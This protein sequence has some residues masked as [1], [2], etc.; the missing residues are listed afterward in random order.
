MSNVSRC[1][2]ARG[3]LLGKNISNV[4][5]NA[6]SLLF[7]IHQKSKKCCT[8]KKLKENQLLHV[9]VKV[10]SEHFFFMS[11]PDKLPYYECRLVTRQHLCFRWNVQIFHSQWRLY[12]LR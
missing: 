3:N 10:F 11:R 2:F 4:H 8:H 12:L 5:N 7:T 1:T 9:T 6:Y